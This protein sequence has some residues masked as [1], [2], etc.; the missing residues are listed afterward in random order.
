MRLID[1]AALVAGVSSERS[2]AEQ[3]RLAHLAAEC[4]RYA[5]AVASEDR[6][7]SPLP[8]PVHVEATTRDRR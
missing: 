4:E 3:T 5:E 7:V 8:A 6:T 2:P 1:S